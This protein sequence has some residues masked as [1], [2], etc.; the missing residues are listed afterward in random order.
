[1]SP[2]I[3]AEPQVGASGCPSDHSAEMITMQSAELGSKQQGL[4]AE[5]NT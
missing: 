2:E 3:A 1:M 4:A 5:R